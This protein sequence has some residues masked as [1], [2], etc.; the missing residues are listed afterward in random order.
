MR[1]AHLD[2]FRCANVVSSFYE[3]GAGVGE[4]V[5]WM[6][7]GRR[8][9]RLRDEEAVGMISLEEARRTAERL[10]LTLPSPLP[11]DGNVYEGEYNEAGERE[12]RA[13]AEGSAVCV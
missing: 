2:V 4:G 5:M 3:Q 10:G 13:G 7:D 9:E 8:A 1:Y 12:G 11:A 6:A